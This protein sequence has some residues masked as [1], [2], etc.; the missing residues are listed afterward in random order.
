MAES[1]TWEIHPADE[2][3]YLSTLVDSIAKLQKLVRDVDLAVTRERQGR[4][5]VVTG[6]QS[7][8]PTISIAPAIN[9]TDSVAAVKAGIRI[10]TAAEEPRNPPLYFSEDALDDLMG[11]RSLFTRRKYRVSKIVLKDSPDT[12]TAIA[13]IQQD[14]KQKVE[15]VTRGGYSLLGSLEGTL[16]AANLRNKPPTFTI[17]ERVTGRPI[18]CSFNEEQWLDAVSNFLKRRARVLVEGK[19]MYF[20]HGIPRYISGL[21]NIRDTAPDESLPKGDFGSIPDFTGGQDSVDYVRSLREK[22]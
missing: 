12:S 8:I 5:W 4:P 18:R 11:M 10:L 14:V 6:L 1:L 7:S 20:R 9:G 2:T 19:V 13:T 21:R 16:E 22:T 17:W 15:R 3:T